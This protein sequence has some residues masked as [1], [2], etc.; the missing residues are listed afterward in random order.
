LAPYRDKTWHRVDVAQQDDGLRPVA[1]FA[2]GVAGRVYR[3]AQSSGRH[4]VDQVMHGLGFLAGWAINLYQHLQERNGTHAGSV[5]RRRYSAAVAAAAVSRS[6]CV[7]AASTVSA[8]CAS[9]AWLITSGGRKRITV[10]PA[11]RAST[12][13]AINACR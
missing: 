4:L 2:H 12:P 10:R 8:A 11:G 5:R 6:G 1:D 9:S 13:S 7:S 3:G